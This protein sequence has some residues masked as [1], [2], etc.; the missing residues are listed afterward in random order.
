MAFSSNF[1]VLGE[2]Y[3]PPEVKLEIKLKP[4]DK[5]PTNKTPVLKGYVL[6]S[7]EQLK[8]IE[9]VIDASEGGRIALLSVALWDSKA[10]D[11]SVEGVIEYR[12][13]QKAP[14]TEEKPASSIYY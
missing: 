13:Y 10:M 14:P 7:K 11:G 12:E 4:Y 9:R 8:S 5:P 3:K 1:D 2:E 6:I